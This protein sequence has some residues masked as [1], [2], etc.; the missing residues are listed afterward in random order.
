M[1]KQKRAAYGEQI[2]P[3]LSAQLVP[4]FGDRFSARN[5]FR[6]VRFAEV[7]P[8]RDIVAALSRRLGIRAMLCQAYCSNRSMA[9]RINLS[10]S[11]PRGAFCN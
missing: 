1:L 7:F 3:T 9:L 10:R 11:R 4:D 2:V 6:T 8:D 5:L